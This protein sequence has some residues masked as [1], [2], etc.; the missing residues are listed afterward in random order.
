MLDLCFTSHP[1]MVS[2]CYPTPGLSDH[3]AVMVKFV[4]SL[5]VKQH[6]RRVFLYKLADWEVIRAELL[7]ISD[8]YMELNSKSPRSVD[9]N[10]LFFR[11]NFFK[12][13]K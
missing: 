10:W 1:S 12:I 2:Q 8:K 4:T 11:N 3:D 6:L 7:S 13:N 9:E 5:A